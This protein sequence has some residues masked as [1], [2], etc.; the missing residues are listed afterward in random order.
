MSLNSISPILNESVS[1]VTATN[2][3]ELGTRVTVDGNDYI[4]VYNSGAATISQGFGAFL[5]SASMSA[6]GASFVVTVSNAASQSGSRSIVGV[7][8][9]AA[10]AASRYGWVCT[11]GVVYAIPDASAVSANSGVELVPGVD[12]G[13]VAFAG[14][15]ATGTPV[16]LTLNSFVTTV[17]TGKV[18]FKSP[19]FS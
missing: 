1:N 13:F 16:A 3:V 11:R 4:Y 7:A 8:H 9:N 17:G 18:A 19:L 5:P 15:S 6:F 10:I 12:G 14:T 2:S